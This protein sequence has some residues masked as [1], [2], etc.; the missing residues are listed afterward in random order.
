MRRSH[1]VLLATHATHPDALA[2]QCGEADEASRTPKTLSNPVPS[3]ISAHSQFTAEAWLVPINL[4][5]TKLIEIVH[6]SID[7][8]GGVRCWG[9]LRRDRQVT[10]AW[11]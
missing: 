3:Q 9:K 6:Q 2:S 8:G 4:A 5:A 7:L 11:S 10:S 1:S